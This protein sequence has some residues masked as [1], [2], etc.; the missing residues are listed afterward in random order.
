M[1]LGSLIPPSLVPTTTV[2]N[3]AIGEARPME[4]GVRARA[5]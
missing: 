2:A 4:G 1:P 3:F 5:I